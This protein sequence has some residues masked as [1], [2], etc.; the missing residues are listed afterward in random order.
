MAKSHPGAAPYLDEQSHLLDEIPCR[1]CGYTLRGLKIQDVCPECA[2]PVGRSVRGDLL[3]YCDPEW[4]ALLVR[5]MNWIACAIVAGFML[6]CFAGPFARYMPSTVW[7]IAVYLRM[8]WLALAISTMRLYGYWLLTTPDPGNVKVD[9]GMNIRRF[10]RL[11]QFMDCVGS[12]MGHRVLTAN[13]FLWSAVYRLIQCIPVAG[14]WCVFIYARRLA[15]RIPDESLARSTRIVMWGLGIT[16]SVVAGSAALVAFARALSAVAPGISMS[17]LTIRDVPVFLVI[18]GICSLALI[19]RYRRA[20]IRVA[21]NARSNRA[22]PP[23]T[24]PGA[25]GAA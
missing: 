2:T 4:V 9:N 3:R 5:G 14:T 22:A 21:A 11:A 18:F 24:G 6:G 7:S 23:Q 13:P 12:V 15:L 20:F 17:R 1:K 19:A 10:I 25:G 8:G 16:M